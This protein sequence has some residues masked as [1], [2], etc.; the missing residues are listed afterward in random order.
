MQH[1]KTAFDVNRSCS[2]ETQTELDFSDSFFTDCADDG[3]TSFTFCSTIETQTTEEFPSFD[4]LLY[5]NMCTQ[6]CDESFYSELGFVNIQTQTAWSQFGVDDSMFVST[7]TQTALSGCFSTS[8]Y[9]TK[10]WPT[11]K[12]NSE[13]S[14]ME[15]Q[16]N[17]DEFRELIAELSKQ[18][19]DDKLL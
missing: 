19:S 16:T 1:R 5:T 7:E 4:H 6:T 12:I 15:T 18:A 2:I 3:D 14:H 11:S 9:M 8:S 13:T 10:S 17:V